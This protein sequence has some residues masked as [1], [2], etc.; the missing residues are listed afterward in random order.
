MKFGEWLLESRSIK[1]NSLDFIKEVKKNCSKYLDLIKSD[2]KII[3]NND[4]ENYFYNKII[5]S[6]ILFRGVASKYDYF[7]VD[8]SKLI[9]KTLT[10][11]IGAEFYTN[12]I[13]TNSK[14]SE[15]PKRSKSLI[16]SNNYEYSKKYGIIYFCF[17][18]NGAQFGVCP[19][20]DIFFSWININNGTSP[21][22]LYIEKFITDIGW[23]DFVATD[24]ETK[25]LLKDI[26]NKKTVLTLETLAFLIQ[27][28]HDNDLLKNYSDY[29]FIGKI[30]PQQNIFNQLEDMFSP[31][32][33]G[34]EL[35]GVKDL[36]NY[37]NGENEIWTSDPCY[38]LTDEQHNDDTISVINEI[39]L[40]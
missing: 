2:L 29:D 8:P 20:K 13:D 34:F 21:F 24:K 27:K 31:E 39:F 7:Y 23:E 38:F 32:M 33:N 1:L 22:P 26:D 35:I 30:N 3:Y 6:L 25:K 36:K 9:R 10:G 18:V 40:S 12:V 14:W 17:P 5:S 15:Y 28:L 37:R 4:N 11:M 19:K 16:L